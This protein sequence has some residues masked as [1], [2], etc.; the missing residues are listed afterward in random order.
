[1]SELWAYPV[2]DD[3]RAFDAEILPFE[4]F[5]GVKDVV[6][7]AL[8]LWFAKSPGAILVNDATLD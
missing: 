4:T 6:G 5:N 1:M 3:R 7:V 8:W 2:D